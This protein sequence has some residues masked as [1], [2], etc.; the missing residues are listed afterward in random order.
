MKRILYENGVN[1]NSVATLAF[2]LAHRANRVKG[3][4][5]W[6]LTF[7]LSPEDVCKHMWEGSLKMY[8]DS[9][10]LAVVKTLDTANYPGLRDATAHPI[11]ADVGDGLL[12]VGYGLL[13]AGWAP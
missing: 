11:S 1:R 8:S 7:K 12:R 3:A 2:A 5:R 4:P 13:Q 9:N 10:T 6:L